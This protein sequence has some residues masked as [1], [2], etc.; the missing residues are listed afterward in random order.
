MKRSRSSN[1]RQAVSFAMKESYL[2]ASNISQKA[3]EMLA[4]VEPLRDR[5]ANIHF[6]PGDAALLVLDM[7]NYFLLPDSHAF[8]PS[9]PAIL[10]GITKLVEIFYAQGRPVVFT[11]HVNTTQNAGMMSVWWHDLIREHSPD[12]RIVAG[13]DTS[14]GTIL[15]KN[16]YDAFLHTRLEDWLHERGVEQVVI[17]GVMTHLCCETTARSAFTHGFEVFFAM[18]GTATYNEA[19][20]CASLLT[21]SYGFVLPVLIDEVLEAMRKNGP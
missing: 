1:S 4:W 3:R 16:Q 14:L 11:R 17:C 20:H 7:Q 10:D 12:S 5:H 9:S 6:S 19:L 18:D 13:L 21:L 8:V 2:T 15:H